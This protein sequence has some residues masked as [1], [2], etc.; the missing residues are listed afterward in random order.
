MSPDT[1][2]D[3]DFC[4]KAQMRGFT[5]H[6][7]PAAVVHVRKR[8]TPAG[9]YRQSR[10]LAEYNTI[11]AKR[12]W[13]ADSSQWDYYREFLHDWYRL[14]RRFPDLAHKNSRC[15]WNWNLGR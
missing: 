9:N 4:F 2:E 11:L 8:R 6:F 13:S 1:L 10:I 15:S 5:L 7:V 3:T 12:Y 14:A